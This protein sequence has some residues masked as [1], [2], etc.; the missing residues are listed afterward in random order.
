MIKNIKNILMGIV[1][2]ELGPIP[3][4]GQNINIFDYMIK[5]LD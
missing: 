5:T 3:M 4:Q 1:D 2:W